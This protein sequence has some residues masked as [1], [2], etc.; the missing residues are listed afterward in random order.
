MY[1]LGTR[2][3]A[4]CSLS[5][6]SLSLAP[7]FL[8]VTQNGYK[9]DSR[10]RKKLTKRNGHGKRYCREKG[11]SETLRYWDLLGETHGCHLSVFFP[12][13]ICTK[14]SKCWVGPFSV[15]LCQRVQVIT[16]HYVWRRTVREGKVALSCQLNALKRGFDIKARRFLQL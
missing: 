9:N 16:G 10:T 15:N 7:V 1:H 13:C 8:T 2:L 11:K 5:M 14:G 3:N 4:V 6:A 12:I